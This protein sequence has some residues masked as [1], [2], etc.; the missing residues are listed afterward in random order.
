MSVTI[1][2]AS[3]YLFFVSQSFRYF[4]PPALISLDRQ[5][6]WDAPCAIVSD[7]RA[8]DKSLEALCSAAL[9]RQPLLEDDDREM[10]GTPVERQ[11][12]PSPSRSMA[13]SSTRGT[14]PW[15]PVSPGRARS[16]SPSPARRRSRSPPRGGQDRP[17]RRDRKRKYSFS[18]PP[19]H[20]APG[21]LPPAALAPRARDLK[22]RSPARASSPPRKRIRAESPRADSV[23]VRLGIDARDLERQ[24]QRL[25]R[26][27]EEASERESALRSELHAEQKR[28]NAKR[29]LQ[30]DINVWKGKAAEAEE[31]VRSQC[32][33]LHDC[34]PDGRPDVAVGTD[35]FEGMCFASDAPV[36]RDAEV[37]RS[38]RKSL[39]NNVR[40]SASSERS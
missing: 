37:R 25:E 5:Q 29:L 14:T 10:K 34:V 32:Q 28:N 35:D 16:R 38:A 23:N 17:Y 26:E 33:R 24:V 36:L 11:R 27:N 13:S 2:E 22:D 18:P 20:F 15:R 40:S 1:S 7:P 6:P 9:V 8:V 4:L 39:A 12:L 21:Q 3:S 31:R 30:E 19:T